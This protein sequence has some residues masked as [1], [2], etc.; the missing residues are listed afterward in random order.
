M[1]YKYFPLVLP[2]CLKGYLSMA[3]QEVNISA[4]QAGTQ[5]QMQVADNVTMAY[6]DTDPSAEPDFNKPL[7]VFMHGMPMSSYIWRNII[8]EVQPRARCVAPDLVGM[9]ASQKLSSELYGWENNVRYLES[10]CQ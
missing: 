1:K 9:G 8:R 2:I 7:L 3:S 6:V 4:Q 5:Q 10:F